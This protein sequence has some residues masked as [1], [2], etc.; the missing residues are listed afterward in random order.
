MYPTLPPDSPTITKTLSCPDGIYLT[1]LC[2]NNDTESISGYIITT[3]PG[4]IKTYVTDY[5]TDSYTITGLEPFISY[6]CTIVATNAIGDSSPSVESSSIIPY[7]CLD[8]PSNLVA[9]KGNKQIFI[10][11]TEPQIPT[12]FPQG[13]NNADIVS[14]KYAIFSSLENYTGEFQAVIGETHK[15]ISVTYNNIEY[16]VKLTA[17]NTFSIGKTSIFSNGITPT[18]DEQVLPEPQNESYIDK[19][20]RCLQIFLLKVPALAH[21]IHE[22]E[23]TI[24]L[25]QENALIYLRALTC[26]VTHEIIVGNPYKRD[27]VTA[28]LIQELA[29]QY[30]VDLTMVT[31]IEKARM[32]RWVALFSSYFV[33]NT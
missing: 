31:S 16:T 13:Y 6:T 27:I 10:T 23:S 3:N 15:T 4:N 30:N 18:I 21:L 8:A 11:W 17:C 9:T 29:D 5:S 1:W 19:A 22:I 25:S 26:N 14:Y 33:D 24:G 20:I 7:E 28:N 2:P 12:N 32:D